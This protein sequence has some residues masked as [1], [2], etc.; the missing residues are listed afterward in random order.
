MGQRKQALLCWA[1]TAGREGT[2]AAGYYRLQILLK[3]ASRSRHLWSQET[4]DTL[5]RAV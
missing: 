2:G 3:A 4:G 5:P 1:N